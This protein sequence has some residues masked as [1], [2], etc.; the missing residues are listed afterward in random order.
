MSVGLFV[1]IKL[2]LNKLS[3]FKVEAAGSDTVDEHQVTI[4]RQGPKEKSFLDLK[5]KQQRRV[6]QEAFDA[7]KKVAEERNVDTISMTG[8]LMK[9]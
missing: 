5:E 1:I 8:Y 9:R 6:S 3:S 4:G 7:V 2:I